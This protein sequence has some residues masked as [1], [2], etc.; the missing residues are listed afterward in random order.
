M[1]ESANIF[2]S[3]LDGKGTEAQISVVLANSILA[4]GCLD[5]DKTM[6]EIREV[7][8]DS[9][10]QKKALNKFKLLLELNRKQSIK[11]AS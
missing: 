2:Y 10:I 8:Y 1:E 3:I 11:N 9:L 7:A 5:S 6:E 4:I